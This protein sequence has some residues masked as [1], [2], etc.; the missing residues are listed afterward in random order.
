LGYTV[1]Y[2]QWSILLRKSMVNVV[3]EISVLIEQIHHSSFIIH[4]SSFI[5][6]HSS[7][8]IHHSSFIIHHL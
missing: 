3:M 8:I 7:F 4:H 1:F 6:H 5:I 2:D